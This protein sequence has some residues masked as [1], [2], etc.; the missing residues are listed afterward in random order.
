[1]T[2]VLIKFVG[3]Y[4]LPLVPLQLR[5][6]S[7]ARTLSVATNVN[8]GIIRVGRKGQKAATLK[9]IKK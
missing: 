5:L 1:M 2:L 6:V 4:P 9:F 3:Y 8:I 7:A